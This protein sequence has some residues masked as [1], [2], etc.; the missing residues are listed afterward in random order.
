[1]GKQNSNFG[2]WVWMGLHQYYMLVK[3]GNVLSKQEISQQIGDNVMASF[4]YTQVRDFLIQQRKV[5][6]IFR[7]LTVFEL[8]LICESQHHVSGEI[9]HILISNEKVVSSAKTQ[10]GKDLWQEVSNQDW[11]RIIILI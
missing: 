7:P 3:E 6:D 1:M 4:Q 11:T 8:L 9:Y 5:M 2:E 10:W